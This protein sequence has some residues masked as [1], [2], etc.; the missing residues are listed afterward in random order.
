MCLF[1]MCVTK[2]TSDH[3]YL[4]ICLNNK[5]TF[6]IDRFR[7]ISK[8]SCQLMSKF[9]IF[10]SSF[11]CTFADKGDCI[12]AKV[13]S[14]TGPE[15]NNLCE[16]NKDIRIMP[17]EIKLL[18]IIRVIIPIPVFP[19]SPMRNLSRQLRESN[20]HMSLFTIDY[21]SS[22]YRTFFVKLSDKVRLFLLYNEI[23]S[24]FFI[25]RLSFLKPLMLF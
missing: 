8:C 20:I 3:R 11:I 6:R 21:V 23:L 7:N 2:V 15:Y 4:L 19:F 12:K 16:L 17:I 24:V 14:K 13:K 18:R 25:P 9:I 10:I 5:N 1:K 22:P